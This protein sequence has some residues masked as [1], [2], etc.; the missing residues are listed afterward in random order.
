M[1]HHI[2]KAGGLLQRERKKIRHHISVARPSAITQWLSPT[3]HGNGKKHGE[4]EDSTVASQFSSADSN[5]SSKVGNGEVAP[6][7]SPKKRK[8]LKSVPPDATLQQMDVIVTKE[9]SGLTVQEFHD[10]VWKERAPTASGDMEKTFEVYLPWLEA[11]GKLNISVSPWQ[12]QEEEGF[13]GTWDMERY[14]DQRIVKFDFKRTTH[15]YTGPPIANVQHT[16]QCRLEYDEN[17]KEDVKTNGDE[18]EAPAPVRCIMAMTV[19]MEGIPFSDCFNV[20]IRWVVT[21][22]KEAEDKLNVQV[23]L[24]VNFVK[25]TV[26]A[27]K[28]RSGTSEETTKAQL[29]LYQAVT[30]AI[31][32]AKPTASKSM[33]LA[34]LSLVATKAAPIAAGST[35]D[36]DETETSVADL[37]PSALAHCAE[38]QEAAQAGVLSESD[39]AYGTNDAGDTDSPGIRCFPF[40]FDAI[41]KPKSVHS[42]ERRKVDFDFGEE[43]VRRYPGFPGTKDFADDPVVQKIQ[44]AE[45]KLNPDPLFYRRMA[46]F[47]QKSHFFHRKRS[48]TLAPFNF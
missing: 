39:Q 35:I 44:R 37:T 11:T 9:L 18:E 43:S 4:E 19:E 33:R 14:P 12:N 27:G 36:L 3:V 21:R 26:L 25:Q 20:Q 38:K 48:L 17:N 28:I 40:M 10:I 24:H 34:R 41:F 30:R 1:F 7:A 6:P 29:S 5:E 31:I 13:E 32:N 15:L 22:S 16:Q 8:K 47:T 23:G 46:V 42:N 2:A 45:L